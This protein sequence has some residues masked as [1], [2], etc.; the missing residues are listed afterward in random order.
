MY[1]S[2]EFFALPHM[3]TWHTPLSKFVFFFFICGQWRTI[4]WV[5]SAWFRWRFSHPFRSRKFH[6]RRLQRI[7]QF[8]LMKWNG[9]VLRYY[10]LARRIITSYLHSQSIFFSSH[11]F[12]PYINYVICLQ[13]RHA[14][15]H[16]SRFSL[17]SPSFCFFTIEFVFFL[18]TKCI[19]LYCAWLS[20]QR[21]RRWY[22]YY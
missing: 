8:F 6:H 20:R 4:Y 21:R 7:E 17:Y 11:F 18:H 9:A 15:T 3:T 10:Y 12:S 5:L 13:S 22:Y 16:A 1:R 19:R 2:N 14:A